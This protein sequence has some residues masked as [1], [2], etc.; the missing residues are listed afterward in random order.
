MSDG[1]LIIGTRDERVVISFVPTVD[2]IAECV[3]T[4][5][6]AMVAAAAIVQAAN[7]A[8]GARAAGRLS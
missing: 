1:G 2:G 6:T 4:P 5:E 7:L 8:L 3:L